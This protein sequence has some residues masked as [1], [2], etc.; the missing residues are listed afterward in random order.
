[1][2]SSALA[3]LGIAGLL[4][5]PA[6][7]LA[8]PAPTPEGYEAPLSTVEVT[9]VWEAPLSTVEKFFTNPQE[10]E[11]E[12]L[13]ETLEAENEVVT[14]SDRFLFDFDSAELRTSAANSL[15][16]VVALLE[17]TEGPIEVVGH[18][19]GM[20]T[21][22]VNQPLSEE[23]A[24]AV[25]DYITSKGIDASRITASGKGSSEP[26]AEN[27]HPDGRDNPEGRQQNRRVEVHYGG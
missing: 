8:E 4:T 16:T 24:Q 9:Q 21:D 18:T 5:V 12:V 14:L 27:T 3:A 11:K 1:M 22:A 26:V 20:G 17:D 15:D 19:D 7:A 13:E 2:R 23:R 10:V 25:A 6:A